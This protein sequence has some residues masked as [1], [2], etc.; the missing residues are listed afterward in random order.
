M[1]HCYH[2]YADACAVSKVIRNAFYLQTGDELKTLSLL[3]LC[4]VTTIK[5]QRFHFFVLC[6]FLF[7]FF[8]GNIKPHLRGMKAHPT[9][10]AAY[11][12]RSCA[13]AQRSSCAGLH[14]NQPLRAP[15]ASPLRF[16][17]ELVENASERPSSVGSEAGA[18]VRLAVRPLGRPRDG[19]SALVQCRPPPPPHAG[20]WPVSVHLHFYAGPQLLTVTRSQPNLHLLTLFL[21]KTSAASDQRSAAGEQGR[22]GCIVAPGAAVDAQLCLIC[23]VLGECFLTRLFHLQLMQISAP[24]FSWL[25]W[26]R[27]KVRSCLKSPVLFTQS[28]SNEA[29]RECEVQPWNKNP[30][31]RS[32]T[33]P[34]P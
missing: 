26:K 17:P 13:L 2:G 8:Q 16:R 12:L 5:D 14:Q 32:H 22:K 25:L 20:L 15:R 27:C 34:L 3:L 11:R 4:C 21:L 28:D 1:W 29:G 7:T 10:F 24:A 19:S 33:V 31:E 30:N 9:F 18:S 6:T 23:T